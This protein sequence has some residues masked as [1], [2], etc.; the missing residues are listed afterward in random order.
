MSELFFILFVLFA[1]VF[2]VVQLSERKSL[3]IGF[4]VFTLLAIAVGGIGLS[5]SKYYG[6]TYITLAIDDLAKKAPLEQ[7]ERLTEAANDFKRDFQKESLFS[8]GA[9]S[10]LWSAIK[11]INYS[12]AFCD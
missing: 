9:S 10:Q 6:R 12:R 3:R 7:R 5:Y 2:I 4:A 1:F 8:L 11:Q